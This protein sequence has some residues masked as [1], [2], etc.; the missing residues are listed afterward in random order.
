MRPLVPRSGAVE[1]RVV[2]PPSTLELESDRS[3]LSQIL[4][5][6]VSNALKFTEEG[7]VSV[8]LEEEGPDVVIRVTDTGIGI[9]P[10]HFGLVF[11]EFGQI[12]SPLQRNVKGN[13]LGLPLSRRLA[14][15]LGGSLTVASEAGSGSTFTLRIP[16]VHPEV[17][18]LQEIQSR[19][20]DPARAPIL[21][22]E[23]DRKTIFLYEKY[24]A[25]AGFQVLPVRSISEAQERLKT[26]R[27]AA[28][29]LDIMLDGESSWSFLGKLKSDPQ[30]RD[31]P[32]LVV[33]VTNKEQKARALG[34]DEFWLKPVDQ[35]LLLR[36][37]RSLGTGAATRV[38]LIDDDERAR[39]LIAHYL[40]GEPYR[41][42]EAAS[43]R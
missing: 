4:R 18:E 33:T 36:K 14:E 19:P 13:G 32:V 20:V 41:L 6:L 39:Y 26:V 7:S 29:V 8:E 38:L 31:I 35:D 28:I 15:L 11:E 2:E 25:M 40:A 21:V 10:E 37:L 5:N 43:G 1:L 24:L 42:I 27:P 3:K 16:R 23:D 22:V 12:E 30:T 9:A 17:R 34:A